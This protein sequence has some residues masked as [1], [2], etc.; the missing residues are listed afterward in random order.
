MVEHLKKVH[1]YV[2]EEGSDCVATSTPIV[3]LRRDTRKQR[4]AWQTIMER[5]LGIFAKIGG[6]L[7]WIS[8][9]TAAM[10]FLLIANA[11]HEPYSDPMVKR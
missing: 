4:E 3:R 8:H 11:F 2:E 10:G 1:S 6:I 7:F 9:L 5:K